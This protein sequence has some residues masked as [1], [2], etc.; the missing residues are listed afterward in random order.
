MF[1][2]GCA[3]ATSWLVVYPFDVIKTT[4]QTGTSTTSGSSTSFVAVT[5]RL[6]AQNGMS[7]FFRGLGTTIARAF[8]VNAITFFGYEKFKGLLDI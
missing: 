7:V 4:I 5:K 1:A 6:Y 8:P 2:G 3:G